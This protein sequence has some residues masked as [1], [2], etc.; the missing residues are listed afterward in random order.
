MYWIEKFREGNLPFYLKIS[1]TTNLILLTENF[2]AIILVLIIL[3]KYQLF[4]IVKT[5]QI[6]TFYLLVYSLFNIAIII[7]LEYFRKEKILFQEKKKFT[8]FITHI[9][10]LITILL[11]SIIFPSLFNDPKKYDSNSNILPKRNIIILIVILFLIL[12]TWIINIIVF[13]SFKYFNE[14]N[15]NDD[16]DC[17]SNDSISTNQDDEIHDEDSNMSLDEFNN[18][19]KVYLEECIIKEISHLLIDSETQTEEI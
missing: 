13:Q 18:N 7:F 3:S 17:K 2:G 9:L 1:L 11:I 16:Y 15:N 8:I 10:I 14:G 5:T 4:I 19:T 12:F 6:N